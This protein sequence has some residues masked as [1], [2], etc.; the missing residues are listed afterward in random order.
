MVNVCKISTVVEKYIFYFLRLKNQYRPKILNNKDVLVGR[1][2][3]GVKVPYGLHIVY[4]ENK[5]IDQLKALSGWNKHMLN[6]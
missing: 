4:E 3:F 1:G 2:I 5:A 6:I